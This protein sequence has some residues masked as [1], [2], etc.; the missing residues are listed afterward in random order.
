MS[1][2]PPSFLLL[3]LSSLHPVPFH[4]CSSSIFSLAPSFLPQSCFISCLFSLHFFSHSFFPL[5]MLV[6]FMS[7]LHPSFLS[8]LLSSLHLTLFH[9]S[10]SATFF[11]APSFLPP[12]CFI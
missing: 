4:V 8:F 5:S 7:L 10:S 2:L 11:F 9:V 12:S 6:S 3:L 1:L